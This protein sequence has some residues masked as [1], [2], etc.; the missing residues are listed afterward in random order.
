MGK[1]SINIKARKERLK[2]IVLNSDRNFFSFSFLDWLRLTKSYLFVVV[3]VT[4]II[5]FYP[6]FSSV[7]Y[8]NT[9]Y[10]FLRNEIDESSIIGSFYANYDEMYPDTPILESADSF[11]SINNILNDERDLTWT[12]EIVDYEV[13]E[14]D[15]ISSIAYTFK[16][17]N[18]SIYW[19]N[20]FDKSHII[21]PWD[22]IKI[23]PVS[24]LIHQVVS[25]D[26]ISSI[27]KKYDVE[28]SAIV[29]QN[30]LTQNEELII[31]DVL[32]IPWAVKEVVTQVYKPVSTKY[33][34][35]TSTTTKTS[36]TDY[37]FSQY[38]NSSYVTDQWSYKLVRRQPQHTF[39]RWNCTRY[40][41]QYKNVNWWWNANQWITNASSKWHQ[42]WTTPALW[43]IVV[44]DWRWY[45]PRYG[46]VW[47]V[48][49]IKWSDIIVS[50]MNYRRLNEITYR[51]VPISDR[52][53]QWYIYVD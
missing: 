39:Y 18:N 9:Q 6:L 19:A 49:D 12:N 32:V 3:F 7:A 29:E 4:F 11:L 37:S 24:W 8:N 2:R 46:H 13:Q 41:A 16:V 1:K 42:T 14:W 34:T 53:I 44:F 21:H 27:A 48:M 35:T 23:P 45:N 17:S 25:W 22:I 51:K 15:S 28:A 52:A 36:T 30:L 33:T 40:V 50:D 5:P 26:S 47:I 38:A 43:S 20:D 31:W 10:D